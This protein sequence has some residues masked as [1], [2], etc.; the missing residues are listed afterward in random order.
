M[1]CRLAAAFG[2][3][4]SCYISVIRR[5]QRNVFK[6]EG[7]EVQYVLNVFL[8]FEKKSEYLFLLAFFITTYTDPE[9]DSQFD[10]PLRVVVSQAAGPV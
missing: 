10:P 5:S 7:W 9:V 6:L 2:P 8:Y 3:L 1:I 4:M